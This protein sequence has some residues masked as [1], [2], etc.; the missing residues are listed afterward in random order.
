ME[1]QPPAG[2]DRSTFNVLFPRS[3]TTLSRASGT[4]RNY[5][6]KSVD[7]VDLRVSVATAH[8]ESCLCASVRMHGTCCSRS[9]T[10]RSAIAL[11]RSSMTRFPVSPAGLDLT[12]H[13]AFLMPG[14]A[15]LDVDPPN[16][17]V[18]RGE[19]RERLMCDAASDN[20]PRQALGALHTARSL[21]KVADRTKD[22]S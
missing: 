16:I 21:S 11:R 7:L 20:C 2:Q 15:W 3:L 5:P 4:S 8:Q 1:N 12:S 9:A 10:H 17:H 14:H 13:P 22:L 19:P 18:C 6:F